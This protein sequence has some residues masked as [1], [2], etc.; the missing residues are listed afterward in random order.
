MRRFKQI[1]F[2]V[3]LIFAFAYFSNYMIG[4]GLRN[5]YKTIKGEVK[6]S[7]PSIIVSEIKTTDVNGY[8]RGTI[9][10][11]TDEDMNS[12]YIKLDLYSRKDVHMGTEYFEVKDLKVGD[13]QDFKIEYRFSNVNH[14]EITCVDEK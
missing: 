7:S 6:T 2:F 11:N 12:I 13:S 4:V 10:N 5:T 14:Y 8:A 1:M 3:I 9:K